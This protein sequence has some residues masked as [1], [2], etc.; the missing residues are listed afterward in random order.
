MEKKHPN[1]V[2]IGKKIRELRKNVAILKK[3][4]RLQHNWVEAMPVE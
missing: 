1:L 3:I 2:K 4:L